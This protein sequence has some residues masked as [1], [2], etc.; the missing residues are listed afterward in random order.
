MVQN[1]DPTPAIP[2]VSS[3]VDGGADGVC[4]NAKA[5]ISKTNGAITLTFS[6]I[7]FILFFWI[8]FFDLSKSYLFEYITLKNRVNESILA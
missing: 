2:L 7:F 4:A 6:K 3:T 5:G 8:G 1:N